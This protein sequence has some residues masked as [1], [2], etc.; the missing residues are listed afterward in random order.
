MYPYEP[1]EVNTTTFLLYKSKVSRAVEFNFLV[2]V[3]MIT[4]CLHL[5]GFCHKFAYISLMKTLAD[6]E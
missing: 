2:V 1:Y 5:P 6:S 4:A 3:V